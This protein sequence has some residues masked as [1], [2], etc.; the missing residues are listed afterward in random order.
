M[1][2]APFVFTPKLSR[3]KRLLRRVCSFHR[4]RLATLLDVRYAMSFLMRS[5]ASTVASASPKA[6]RRT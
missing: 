5:I 1:L 3:E 2:E 6:V 4:R